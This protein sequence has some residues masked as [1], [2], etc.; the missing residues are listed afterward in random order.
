[1][2]DRNTTKTPE[3][4]IKDYWKECLHSRILFPLRLK[5]PTMLNF[6][7]ISEALKPQLTDLNHLSKNHVIVACYWKAENRTLNI[8][9][10]TH[11]GHFC[12]KTIKRETR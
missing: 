9:T 7:D 3:L 6:P 8:Q 10:H 12:R 5:C 11:T 1:M 2:Y 4:R